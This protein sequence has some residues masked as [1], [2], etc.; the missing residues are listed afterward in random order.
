[1]SEAN[2]CTNCGISFPELAPQMFSFNN[3]QGACPSCTGLGFRLEVDPQLLVPNGR[4]SLHEGA[5]PYWGELRKKTDS[6]AYRALQSIA[7][8]YQFGMDTP[9]DEMSERARTA[10]IYGSNK[11]KI[12]FSW[13]N[14]ESGSHG[15]FHRT[16]EGLASE[17]TRRFHQ[18]DSEWTR[19]M[20]A[21]YMSEQPCPDCKG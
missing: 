13:N 21:S 5:V 7:R 20:Y 4:L 8:H 9:W 17:I 18:T 3:P 12:R 19:D 16:W 14:H 15:E 2:T 6:W 1:M 11:E 10:I